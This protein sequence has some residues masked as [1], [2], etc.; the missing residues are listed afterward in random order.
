MDLVYKAMSIGTLLPITIVGK[1]YLPEQPAIYAVNHQS[2]LDVPLVGNLLQR[3]P[4]VW[5][6][7]HELTKIPVI[8]WIAKRFGVSVD[9]TSPSCALQSLREAIELVKHTKRSLIIFPEGGRFTD[10][11]IHQFL[12]GFAIIAKKMKLP[13]VPVCLFNTGIAYPPSSFFIHQ[14]TIKIVVGQP[15]MF[16]ADETDEHFVQRVRDWFIKT[17]AE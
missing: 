17:A 3:M 7:K 5:L 6:L 15:F 12:W 1:Q 8:G 16:G 4:H 10:G 2:S 13:V 11:A 9:R 14:T